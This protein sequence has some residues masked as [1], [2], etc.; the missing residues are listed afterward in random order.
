MGGH[1]DKMGRDHKP[2]FLF[3]FKKESSSTVKR[4][5]FSFLLNPSKHNI[6][7]TYIITN[8]AL[9][10][11]SA[12][13]SHDQAKYNKPIVN[14]RIAYNIISALELDSYIHIQ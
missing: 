13:G 10:H 1:T 11:V 8:G 14:Y 12:P 5:F 6:N 4:T 7:E 9:L 3:P 2:S